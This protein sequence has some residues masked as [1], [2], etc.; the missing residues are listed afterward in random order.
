MVTEYKGRSQNVVF[1]RVTL[2]LNSMHSKVKLQHLD[3]SLATLMKYVYK[4]HPA[5]KPSEN[6]TML[7][8]TNSFRI[9]L[10]K[11]ATV[12]VFRLLEQY[13]GE[14]ST[15]KIFMRTNPVVAF[16]SC[17][18][19]GFDCRAKW[20]KVLTKYGLCSQLHPNSLLSKKASSNL[21]LAMTVGV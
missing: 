3:P 12:I 18:Y 15:K 10:V 13:D 16:L 14:E 6:E 1:P 8:Y 21:V 19:R 4:G 9:V 17:S 2:C 11:V 7:R 5:W 20:K